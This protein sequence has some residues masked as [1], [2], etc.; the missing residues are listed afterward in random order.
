MLH[1]YPGWGTDIDGF[2]RRRSKDTPVVV[3]EPTVGGQAQ[4]AG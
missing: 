1:D 3:L 2:A 4:V